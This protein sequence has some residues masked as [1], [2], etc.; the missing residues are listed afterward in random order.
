MERD[1]TCEQA[2]LEKLEQG[3]HDMAR[4]RKSDSNGH[5]VTPKKARK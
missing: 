4:S 1:I 3:R 2:Y 5:I